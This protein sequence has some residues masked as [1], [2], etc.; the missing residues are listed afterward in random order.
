MTHTLRRYALA[1]LAGLSACLALPVAPASAETLVVS[2]ST[3]F[4]SALI[5]PYQADIEAVAGHQLRVVPSRSNLGLL[6]L[7]V[8]EADLAMISSSLEHEV[9]VMSK[10][11]PELP[12]DRL[13]GFLVHRT[14]VAFAVN[15]ANPL[16]SGSA[17]A[18]RRILTGDI[19]NWKDLGGPDQPINVVSPRAGGGVVLSIEQQMLGGQRI[20][21]RHPIILQF[22]PQVAPV[23]ARVS[24][25]LGLAQFGELQRYKLPEL[26]LNT[27]IEQQLVLV[28]RDEPTPAM[29]AVIDAA[30]RVAAG[31]LD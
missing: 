2:G 12:W 8:G 21:P 10:V 26:M 11:R 16:R 6:A 28:T 24:G 18:V 1:A 19:D 3:T 5:V 9:E 23:V 4:N 29:E 25:A 20:A 13:H 15:P 31:M 17:A 7:L 22:G 30:R 14:R 27:L